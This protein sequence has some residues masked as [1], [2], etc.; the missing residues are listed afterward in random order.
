MKQIDLWAFI[1][2]SERD[3]SHYFMSALVGSYEQI[4]SLGSALDAVVTKHSS[5]HPNFQVDFELHA[6]EIMG[7]RGAYRRVP[8]RLRFAIME[9][10]FKA[11]GDSEVAIFVS[12]INIDNLAKKSYRKQMP[13]RELALQWLLEWVNNHAKSRGFEYVVKVLA[14]EHHTAPESNTKLA[15]YRIG[16]T[17][18]YASSKLERITGPMAFVDSKDFRG[19]QASDAV[20]YLYNRVHTIVETDDRAEAAKRRWWSAISRNVRWA[21]TW[22]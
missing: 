21:R 13:A 11:I 22:P 7:G 18:G 12:G 19:L 10:V 17:V 8:P 4:V 1:D 2:E 5:S 3:K 15:E 20:T 16:G 14:D 6:C 9:D